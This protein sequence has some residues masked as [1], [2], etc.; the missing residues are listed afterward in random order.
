MAY[1]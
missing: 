1:T